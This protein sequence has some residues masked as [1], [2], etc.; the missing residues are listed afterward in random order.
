MVYAQLA[1]FTALLG[2]V[3]FFVLR[4][5][6]LGLGLG[7][8]AFGVEWGLFYANSVSTV[9]PLF[10]FP[11]FCT[12]AT[13]LIAAIL[14]I[15]LARR[16]G[17][18]SGSPWLLLPVLYVASLIGTV[19]L[20][21]HLFNA[22]AYAALIGSIEQREWTQDIQPKDPKHMRMVSSE[23]AL[24]M[25]R[26]AVANA[27][28]I[29]SQFGLDWDRL[30]LQKVKDHLVYVIP[31]DFAGFSQW[32]SSVGSPGFIIVDAEDPE[33][34]PRL[35]ELPANGRMHY[36]PGAY[37]GHDL[38]RHLREQGYL[39]DGLEEPRFELD[40]DER[41]HWVV[42]VYR[43]SLWWGGE[44][45]TGVATVDPASGAIDWYTLGQAPAWIDRVF[46]GNLIENY[47]DERG[48]YSGGWW[49]S[50]WGKLSLTSAEKPIL[51][52]GSDN[53]PQWVTGVTSTSEKDDSLV[54]LMYT[55]SHT[56]KTIY[57]RTNGG[58]TDTAIVQ[59]VDA[60]QQVKFKHLHASTPQIYNVSGV[61]T[62]VVPLL[63]DNHAYQGMALVR[64]T[65]PQDVAVGTTQIEA[66]RA[67]EAM[68][69]RKGQQIEVG[70]EHERS[71]ASSGFDDFDFKLARTQ[72]AEAGS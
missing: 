21:S 24:Y 29:G 54:G 49:N 16:Q 41:P 7:L 20:G 63:N 60:N 69:F 58:A 33:R 9:Y 56:G 12:A 22:G 2:V 55:D 38:E 61:M 15:R 26:K 45:L 72:H 70:T 8:L 65:N 13:W 14:C 31:F 59:A 46:P 71:L 51:V 27:G 57:Y 35:V 62:S 10:G 11:G 66:L 50:F 36:T 44:K 39:N 67:Y 48:E 25:A 37:F 42:P 64:V 52:Y 5:P 43:L 30:T 47:I 17:Q 23:N 18:K 68:A 19:I 34:G 3:P 1:F 32:Q 4:H 28:A 53:R 40:D 6:R